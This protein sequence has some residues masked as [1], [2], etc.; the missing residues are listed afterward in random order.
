MNIGGQNKHYSLAKCTKTAFNNYYAC[1][2]RY[3]CNDQPPFQSIRI[4]IYRI[5]ALTAALYMFKNLENRLASV[6]LATHFHLQFIKR[7]R[8]FLSYFVPPT[9]IQMSRM[10]L[11]TIKS[12]VFLTKYFSRSF[13]IYRNFILKVEYTEHNISHSAEACQT[14]S[15]FAILFAL[16]C[17]QTVSGK[18]MQE[19]G[20][21]F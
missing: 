21:K 19:T 18:A 16:N 17:I 1:S 5:A 4:H 14:P 10:L 11:T 6:M 3:P 12:T 13:Q 20:P 9:S 7:P 2:L 8:I 15:T